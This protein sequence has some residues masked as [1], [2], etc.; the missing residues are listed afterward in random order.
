[1]NIS[2]EE[3]HQDVWIS[4]FFKGKAKPMSSKEDG[5]YANFSTVLLMAVAFYHWLL[6]SLLM[7]VSPKAKV[8]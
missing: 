8:D 2:D 7:Y 3:L 6:N 1:M 5:H 4:L